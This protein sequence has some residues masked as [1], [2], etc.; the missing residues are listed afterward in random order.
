LVR[1]DI[2]VMIGLAVLM[3]VMS[4]DGKISRIDGL[5]LFSGAV[6]YTVVAIRQSRQQTLTIATE[7]SDLQKMGAR[8]IKPGQAGLQLG[9]IVIGLALLVLGSR[10]LVN[11]AVA[12]ARLLGASELIIGLTI[13]AVGTSMPE[14]ATSIAAGI[15]GERDIAVGNAVG[16]N[17]FNILLVLGLCGIVAPRAVDVSPAALR[18]D[19]PGMIAGMVVCLP[20]FFTSYQISRWE[21]ILFLG[22][23]SAYLA[24]LFLDA[25]RH[26][27]LPAFS[28]IMLTFVVP[29]TA[30]TL[31]GLTIRAFRTNSRYPET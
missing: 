5:I 29:I 6:I 2:P 1:W 13:V 27:A 30:I 16:S 11:G 10:W 23:Y 18:F 8:K 21:G 28:L 7:A 31:L 26:Q 9:L 19:I 20:I 15:R 17:I 4:L 12:M 25:T 24:Y 14:I 22:Y 3:L